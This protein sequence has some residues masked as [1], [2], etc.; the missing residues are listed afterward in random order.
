MGRALKNRLFIALVFFALPYL[1]DVAYYGDLTPTHYAQETLDAPN[2]DCSNA[3][4]LLSADQSV[5][6]GI[7]PPIIRA[8]YA[9]P[10]YGGVSPQSHFP[11]PHISRPP[12]VL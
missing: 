1:I 6:T 11:P 12:P 9:P 4:I 7:T 8:A 10:V 5:A 2:E 3:P